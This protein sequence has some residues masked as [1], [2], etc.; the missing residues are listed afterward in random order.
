MK[1][2]GICWLVALLLLEACRP[3]L[4]KRQ[5]VVQT[6]LSLVGYP[7]RMGGDRPETGFDCSGF[8]QYVFKV[9]GITLPR[10]TRQQLKV[11]RRVF[12]RKFKP[13]DLL[14]FKISRN[15]YHVG[16]YIGH[17]KMIHVSFREK[18]VIIEN[19][20]TSYWMKKFYRAK[21]VL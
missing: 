9:H 4:K 7:Y 11:G 21:R 5:L 15:H 12:R 13:G 6:A 8:V 3:T 2:I 19:V 18:K 16:I 10:T 17:G 1:K 14:F 20:K